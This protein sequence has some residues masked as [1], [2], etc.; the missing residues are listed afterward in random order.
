MQDLNEI[1]V[2]N[3]LSQSLY[4]PKFCI[5]NLVSTHGKF[6][7]KLILRHSSYNLSRNQVTIVR[8][9]SIIF[10]CSHTNKNHEKT[11]PS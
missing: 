9:F 6:L 10:V 4:H 8:I 3:Y 11:I 7:F 1:N 5:P 2:Y